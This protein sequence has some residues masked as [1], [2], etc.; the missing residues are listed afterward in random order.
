M[1]SLA[2]G[3]SEAVD[4]RIQTTKLLQR[5]QALF[6]A[7]VQIYACNFLKQLCSMRSVDQ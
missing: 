7:N 2:Q 5:A 1:N 3:L 6:Y 4:Q